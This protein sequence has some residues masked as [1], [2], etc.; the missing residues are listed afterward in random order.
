MVKSELVSNLLQK[1]GMFT[2]DELSS[3]QDFS[4]EVSKNAE[5]VR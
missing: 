1:G 4:S 2:K 3:L 5:N